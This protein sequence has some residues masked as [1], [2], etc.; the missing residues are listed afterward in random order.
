MLGFVL[1]RLLDRGF[2]FTRIADPVAVAAVSFGVVLIIGSRPDLRA[3]MNAGFFRRARGKIFYQA[4]LHRQIASVVKN[5]GMDR[6]AV[7]LRDAETRGHRVVVKGAVA[8]Q[9]EHRDRAAPA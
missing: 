6:Q 1:E 5:H 7:F 9:G 8:D 3:E 4:R 2:D